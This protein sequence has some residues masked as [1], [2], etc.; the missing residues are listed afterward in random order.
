[1]SKPNGQK[2]DEEYDIVDENTPPSV[3]AGSIFLVITLCKLNIPKKSVS[4]ACKISEVTISK[5]F[6]K[7]SQYSK[8]LIPDGAVK[9]Y[10]IE[11][12]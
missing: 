2:R 6:K 5:C 11:F 9:K 10:K 1:M 12:E 3:A 8:K 7:L 4:T